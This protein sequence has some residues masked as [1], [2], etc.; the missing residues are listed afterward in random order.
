[1]PIV[2]SRD[3]GA[4]SAPEYPQAKQ[5]LAWEKVAKAWADANQERLRALAAEYASGSRGK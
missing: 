3:S 2:I 1:M 5:E 4:I